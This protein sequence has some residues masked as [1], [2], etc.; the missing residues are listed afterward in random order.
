MR[1]FKNIRH[2][3]GW[4]ATGI[5]AAPTETGTEGEGSSK[6]RTARKVTTKTLQV[7]RLTAVQWTVVILTAVQRTVGKLAKKWERISSKG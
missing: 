2:P 3:G 1:N 6:L 7:E 5:M 4:V